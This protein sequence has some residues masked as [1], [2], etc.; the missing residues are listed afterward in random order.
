MKNLT[1]TGLILLIVGSLIY[2]ILIDPTSGIARALTIGI[3]IGGGYA[4]TRYFRKEEK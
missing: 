3:I 1:I 2:L 4:L